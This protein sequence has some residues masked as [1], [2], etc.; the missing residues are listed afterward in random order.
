MEVQ[1]VEGVIAD[2]GVHQLPGQQRWLPH[3]YHQN[4]L[5]SDSSVANDFERQG[6]ADTAWVSPYQCFRTSA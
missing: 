6:T 4:Y 3:V 1:L 2:P 5:I